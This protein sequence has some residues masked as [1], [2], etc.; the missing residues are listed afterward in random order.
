MAHRSLHEI[1]RSIPN[2]ICSAAQI[3]TIYILHIAKCGKQIGISRTGR[4]FGFKNMDEQYFHM[5]FE[6]MSY[7]HRI[8]LADY[9]DFKSSV[10][11]F[12]IEEDN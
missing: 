4:C 3:D 8:D 2:R 10:N 6:Y 12:G 9:R 5:T 7:E 1:I 11:I